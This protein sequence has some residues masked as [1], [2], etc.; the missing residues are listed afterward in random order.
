MTLRPAIVETEE[1]RVSRLTYANIL[2][3]IDRGR[4]L[5]IDETGF[6]LH[7]HV[8]YGYVLPGQEAHY[9]VPANREKK[10]IS[11]YN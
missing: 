1:M 3:T 9:I 8:N 7:T 10:I 6:N 2:S 11:S 4:L 5:L